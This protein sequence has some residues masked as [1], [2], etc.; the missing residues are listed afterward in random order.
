MPIPTTYAYEVMRHYN[1][2]WNSMEILPEWE[3]RV[4]EAVQVIR[5]SQPTY[6]LFVQSFNTDLPW[7]V[8]AA[9]HMMECDCRFDC[10]LHNGDSLKQRTIHEPKGRPLLPPLAGVGKPYMWHESA[11]DALR[12]KDWHNYHSWDIAHCLFRIE[13]YNGDYYRNHNMNSPYL[14]SGSNHYTR[15]KFVEDHVFDPNAVSQQV[16]AAVLIKRLL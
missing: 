11:K 14:W 13:N 10:H 3:E 8:V 6:E 5:R 1:T 2:L 4:I 9:I 15:G 7:Y 16:G 12:M